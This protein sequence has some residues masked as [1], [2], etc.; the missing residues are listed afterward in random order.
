MYEC[1]NTTFETLKEFK[2]HI[3]SRRTH[4]LTKSNIIQVGL[5]KELVNSM[6]YN[7]DFFMR[8]LNLSRINDNDKFLLPLSSDR[9]VIGSTLKR[10]LAV[11]VEGPKSENGLPTYVIY[12]GNLI[13]KINFKVDKIGERSSRI[14]LITSFE[15]DIGNLGR[16][17]PSVVLKKLSI[18]PSP[19]KILEEFEK[20]IRA[21]DLYS[22]DK[23]IAK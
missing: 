22:R 8:M 9:N 20:E 15:A 13:Y 6:L 19:N 10:S 18:L 3:K 16:L 11:E 2:A 23:E 5:P 1:C 4:S 21:I 7:K 12:A 14:S 17:M